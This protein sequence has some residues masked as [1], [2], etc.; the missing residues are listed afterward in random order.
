[1]G[2]ERARAGDAPQCDNHQYWATIE[3]IGTRLYVTHAD[4]REPL[5]TVLPW[6][7]SDG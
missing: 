6:A 7:P 1:M 3:R 2:Y 4:Q 5:P